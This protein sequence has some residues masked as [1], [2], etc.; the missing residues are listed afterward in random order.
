[1]LNVREE[2]VWWKGMKNSWKAYGRQTPHQETS[3][4]SAALRN[5]GQMQRL[6]LLLFSASQHS[7]VTMVRTAMKH[8]LW[9]HIFILLAQDI[10]SK[11]HMVF[12]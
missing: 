6:L 10:N 2:A 9:F 8:I 4:K 5:M 11:V 12:L 3:L 1:M 7:N